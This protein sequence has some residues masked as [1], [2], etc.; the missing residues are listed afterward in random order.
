MLVP[1]SHVRYKDTIGSPPTP[2]PL[3]YMMGKVYAG[4]S[5]MTV[6]CKI[7]SSVADTA[8][9][10]LIVKTSSYEIHNSQTANSQN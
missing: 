1:I 5:L 4:G 8:S 7:T 6:L 10:W 3:L 9:K 2:P